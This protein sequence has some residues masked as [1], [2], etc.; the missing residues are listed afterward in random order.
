MEAVAHHKLDK[1][2]FWN[3]PMA[4]IMSLF[5]R[6]TQPIPRNGLLCAGHDLKRETH[7]KY[8][9][10]KLESAPDK[11]DDYEPWEDPLYRSCCWSSDMNFVCEAV[12]K[13]RGG[14]IGLHLKNFKS[15]VEIW[16]A[17]GASTGLC[18]SD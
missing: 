12:E 10:S 1:E 4:S 7:F 17:T 9:R 16:G 3:L 8:I 5:K 2:C 14:H 13:F 11:L 18:S 6:F 15:R